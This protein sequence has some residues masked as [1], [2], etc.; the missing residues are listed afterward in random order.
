M[1]EDKKSS[2][3]EEKR[4]YLRFLVRYKAILYT[5][6]DIIPATVL[7]VSEGGVG[8][9]V[10]Q[11]LQFHEELFIKIRFRL[12]QAHK[13]HVQ[14]RGQ[15]IWTEDCFVNN[16]CAC[17]LEIKEITHTDFQVFKTLLEELYFRD[18]IHSK[19]ERKKSAI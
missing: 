7:D 8:M 18:C 12:G 5:D 1:E 2:E 11:R 16:M 3:I 15:I 19:Y 4:R 13:S 10:P 6:R 14:F 9:I 17:G